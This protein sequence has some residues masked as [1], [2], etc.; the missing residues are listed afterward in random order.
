MI[1]AVLNTRLRKMLESQLLIAALA[2][3]K[4]LA[5]MANQIS[6][7][8]LTITLA[9]HLRHA[10]AEAEEETQKPEEALKV[11]I[12]S[13]AGAA[14]TVWC[15]DREKPSLCLHKSLSV[16]RDPY[17]GHAFHW[18]S[19]VMLDFAKGQHPNT[20]PFTQSASAPHCITPGLH[21]RW[22]YRALTNLPKSCSRNGIAIASVWVPPEQS[23]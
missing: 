11:W 22:R 21:V 17:S 9:P 13:C 16:T 3:L 20:L 18:P 14:R 7:G 12:A 2:Q 10:A 15:A 8:F 23:T 1:L 19:D 6:K 4:S 5:T